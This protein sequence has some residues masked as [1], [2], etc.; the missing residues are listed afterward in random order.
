MCTRMHTCIHNALT[1]ATARDSLVLG[2]LEV[3]LAHKL[4]DTKAAVKVC[5]IHATQYND[6]YCSTIL[7]RRILTLRCA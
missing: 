5:Y 3:S 1:Q 4:E 7:C 2:Q 6:T